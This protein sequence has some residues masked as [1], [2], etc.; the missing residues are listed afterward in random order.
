MASPR[1][2]KSP[3]PPL[4]AFCNAF[5]TG[6]LL[7]AEP[8]LHTCATLMHFTVPVNRRT[9]RTGDFRAADG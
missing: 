9:G 7:S 5:L 1:D 2:V 6:L 4:A 8:R 3:N